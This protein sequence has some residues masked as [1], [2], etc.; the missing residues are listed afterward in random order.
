MSELRGTQ[1]LNKG[2]KARMITF[3]NHQAV[4]SFKSGRRCKM[5]KCST[6]LSIYN[7]NRYCYLCNDRVVLE[8]R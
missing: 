8:K 1:S 7:P 4:E 6:P 5:R 3:G 2:E